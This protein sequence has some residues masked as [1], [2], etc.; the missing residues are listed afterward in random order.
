M[1]HQKKYENFCP[2]CHSFISSRLPERLRYFLRKAL[3]NAF[4]TCSPDVKSVVEGSILTIKEMPK[5]ITKNE[6]LRFQS[7]VL[8]DSSKDLLG[9]HRS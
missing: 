7:K 6:E 8:R 4:L 9:V 1:N 5:L 3:H 2:Q